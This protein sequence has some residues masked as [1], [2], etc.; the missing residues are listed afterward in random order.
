MKATGED[1]EKYFSKVKDAVGAKQATDQA[2]EKKRRKEKKLKMKA[3]HNKGR[4]D[5]H[6][7]EDAGVQLAGG[8]EKEE[9]DDDGQSNEYVSGDDEPV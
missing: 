4:D 7:D 3:R 9:G 5:E 6:G 8:S 2:A 1:R